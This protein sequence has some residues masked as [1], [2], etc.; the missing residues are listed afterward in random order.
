MTIK[1]L[2]RSCTSHH[3]ESRKN[4]IAP[5]RTAAYRRD[6]FRRNTVL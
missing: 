3:S 5:N 4:H 2:D 6:W 1:G